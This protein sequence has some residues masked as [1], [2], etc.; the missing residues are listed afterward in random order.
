MKVLTNFLLEGFWL[1]VSGPEIC[2]PPAKPELLSPTVLCTL[3]KN[4]GLLIEFTHWI[5]HVGLFCWVIS[6]NVNPLF[7][8]LGPNKSL[9]A[10]RAQCWF[11][12][13]SST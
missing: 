10:I 6:H 5:E 9:V 3:C 8:I 11:N 13:F 1:K 2:N 7:G 4:S 12:A